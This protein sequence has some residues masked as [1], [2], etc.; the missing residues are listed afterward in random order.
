MQRSPS[1]STPLARSTS[2]A[3]GPDRAGS[4]RGA[5]ADRDALPVEVEVEAASPA[6]RPP[7]TQ[8][9]AGSFSIVSVI[10]SASFSA[11]IGPPNPQ[12]LRSMSAIRWS[13]IA[14]T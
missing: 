1:A 3:A 6:D 14:G 13:F 5:P 11:D 2:S 7:R 8:R 4:P 9:T 10:T 12:I